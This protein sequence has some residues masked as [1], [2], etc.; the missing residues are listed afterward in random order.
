MAAGF[1]MTVGGQLSE[2]ARFHAAFV[3]FAT[4]HAVPTEV[5][6]NLQVVLDELLA[7]IVSYGLA[8]R[9]GGEAQVQVALS[10]E[11]VAVTLSDNGAAFDPFA[12]VAPD[13]TLSIED[14]QI[15][16]LGIHLVKQ[17]MD[18]VSYARRDNQNVTT[19]MK[20]FTNGTAQERRGGE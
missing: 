10:D 18:E 2:V 9:E 6:R 3:E 20:R 11:G 16:G 13:T 19:I 7:N 8:G 17:M 12:R 4:A 5:R 14:R 15:G 1:Q